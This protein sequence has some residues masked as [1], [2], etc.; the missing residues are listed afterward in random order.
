MGK[1]SITAGGPFTF[2]QTVPTEALVTSWQ[3]SGKVP[4]GGYWARAEA[5]QDGVIVYAQLAMLS[6]PSVQR[7]FTFGPTP[8]WSG[9]AAQGTVKLL[10]LVNGAFGRPLAEDTF[11]VSG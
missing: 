2:G 7:G 1:A 10:K 6:E 4:D 5:Y 8:S 9:G 11:E 3:G